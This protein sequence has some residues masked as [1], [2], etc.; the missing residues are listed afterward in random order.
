[1]L[2]PEIVRLCEEVRR[3]VEKEVDPRAR[4]IEEHDAI[5]EELIRMARDMGSSASRFRSSTAASGSTSPA[6]ARS[7]R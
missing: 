3:F 1:M 4:W 6:S 7:R 5:P 2:S